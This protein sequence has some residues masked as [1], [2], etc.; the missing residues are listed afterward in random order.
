MQATVTLYSPTNPDF[1]CAQVYADASLQMR[2][3]GTVF[4]RAQPYLNELDSHMASLAAWAEGRE[5]LESDAASAPDP[6]ASGKPSASAAA[7]GK[8]AGGMGMGGVG[9]KAGKKGGKKKK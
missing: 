5:P 1:M 9:G 2:A 4:E 3:I 6:T 7:G 8:G